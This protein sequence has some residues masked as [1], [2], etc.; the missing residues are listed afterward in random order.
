MTQEL[1]EEQDAPGAREAG[2]TRLPGGVKAVAFDCFGTLMDIGDEHFIDA[3]GSICLQYELGIDGKAL[4]ER[5]LAMNKEV[6]RDWGRDPDRPT[7]GQEPRFGT[8]DELWTEQFSRTFK[9]LALS[10]DAAGAHRLVVER[11]CNATAFPEVSEVLARL[12]RRYR[13][14]LL[15]NADEAWLRPCLQRAGI[16]AAFELVVSSESA[17]A[18]KPRAKIFQATAALLGLAPGEVLYVGD[19]PYADVQGARNAG[20]PVVWLNRYAAQLP[21][22]I[23]PPD[24][25]IS[26]LRGLLPALLD[27]SRDTVAG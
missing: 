19:S 14:C 24:L 23:A 18:Y 17:R 20:L 16:E 6:W 1:A 25:E 22:K 13:L 26:D 27:A 11:L 3:M 9:A 2:R 8:Y 7:E 21:E 12:G 10:G 15:S 4:F 5:W